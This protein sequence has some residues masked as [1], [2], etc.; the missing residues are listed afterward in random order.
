MGK[1]AAAEFLRRRDVPVVDTDELARV[2][3]EPGRSAVEEIRQRFG[4]KVVGPDGALLRQKLAEIVFADP[5][6]RAALEAIVHPPIRELWRRQLNAWRD[7]GKQSAAVVIPL[8]F[9]TKAENEFDAVVCVACSPAE[10]KRRLTARGWTVRIEEKIVRA[11]HVV[12]TE[13]SLQRTEEQLEWILQT[14]SRTC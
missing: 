2:V 8:L 14:I 7:E 6:A 5:A 1:S 4:S 3:V 12:W 9:E 10:Q 13:G 11:S